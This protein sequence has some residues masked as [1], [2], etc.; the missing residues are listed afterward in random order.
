[1]P[2]KLKPFEQ[3]R[4]IPIDVLERFIELSTV[5]KPALF[6]QSIFFSAP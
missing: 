3:E 4:F 1:M 5:T 6:V 2:E